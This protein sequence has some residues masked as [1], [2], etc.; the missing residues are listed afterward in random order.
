MADMLGRDRR[1]RDLEDDKIP[2]PPVNPQ[3]IGDQQLYRRFKD[4]N[5]P[6]FKGSTEANLSKDWLREVDKIFKVMDCT[7]VEKLK[8]AEFTLKNEAQIRWE[9]MG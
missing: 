9:A 8:L 7:E 2:P 4:C 3:P 5:P 6:I 1:Q